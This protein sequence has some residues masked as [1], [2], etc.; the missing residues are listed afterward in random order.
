M[1]EAP[2]ISIVTPS[3]RSGR[4]LPE[5]Q[6]LWFNADFRSAGDQDWA[7]RLVQAGVRTAV[8]PRFLSVFT[9]T[10]TNLGLDANAARERQAFHATAPA[11]ARW[12]SPGALVSAKSQKKP[13]SAPQKASNRQLMNA[14]E[15]Q[16]SLKRSVKKQFPIEPIKS[17]SGRKCPSGLFRFILRQSGSKDLPDP[18]NPASIIASSR[19]R[20]ASPASRRNG[21]GSEFDPSRRGELNRGVQ[22]DA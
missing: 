10:G 13:C 1:N 12:L 9:E 2:E 6:Q 7:L 19:P 11:W 18:T 15:N 4:W 20:S 8:L 14:V 16:F 22:V 3:Y 17:N 21:R 5:Q